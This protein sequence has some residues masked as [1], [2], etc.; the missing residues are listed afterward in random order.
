KHASDD[1]LAATGT[2]GS[3]PVVD[4]NQVALSAEDRARLS[5]KTGATQTMPVIKGGQ[6]VPGE[7]MNEAEMLAEFDSSKKWFV[8][9][10]V[11]VV[12]VLAAVLYFLLGSRSPTAKSPPTPKPEAVAAAPPAVRPIEPSPVETKPDPPAPAT[13]TSPPPPSKPTAKELLSD[14]E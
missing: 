7:R 6:P 12:I 5:L 8:I 1:P 4:E 2:T 10:G 13:P 11:I 3:R 9:A 14:A